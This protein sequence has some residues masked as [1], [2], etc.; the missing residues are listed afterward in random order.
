[1]ARDGR[2]IDGALI[3]SGGKTAFVDASALV[4]LA[5][6]DDASHPAAVAGY[7]E[8]IESGFQLVTSDL[9][10]AEAHELV[11]AMLGRDVAHKWLANCRIDICCVIAVD[12]AVA[13]RALDDG[14]IGPEA[15]LTEAIHLALL[16]RLEITDVFAVDRRFLALLG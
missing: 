16:D 11:T 1:V 7:H 3:A 5:D 2:R 8:L 13:R 4:A 9:A 10:L 6:R 15:T 14:S 12:V